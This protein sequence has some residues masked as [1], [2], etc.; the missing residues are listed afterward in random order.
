MGRIATLLLLCSMC[1]LGAAALSDKRF[2]VELKIP[3]AR[4]PYVA[5][6]KDTWGSY[7]HHR[8]VSPG[9]KAKFEQVPAGDFHLRVQFHSGRLLT[10]SFRVDRDHAADDRDLKLELRARDAET[11]RDSL[12]ARH[13]VTAQELKV[14]DDVQQRFRK[15]WKAMEIGSWFEARKL[16]EECVEKAPG[17]FDAWN[18]LGVVARRVDDLEAAEGHFRMALHLRPEAYEPHA[19]L[20]EVLS[21]LEKRDEALA[22]A[23]R[24]H[25]IRPNDAGANAMLGI[26]YFLAKQ[27]AECIPYLE[28]AMQAD[29]RSYYYPQI[30]LAVAYEKL[31]RPDAAARSLEHWLKHHATNP[32]RPVV[33]AKHRELRAA[34]AYTE[35]QAAQ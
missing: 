27:W 13:V 33:E 2:R 32:D 3:D 30:S 19:N 17:Y 1:A 6:L 22:M 18:N 10:R 23:K 25:R 12:G 16:L 8:Q 31:G 26:Q 11:T 20:S 29:P 9:G 5:V 14:S 35:T 34:S 4:E 15:A 28:A 7:L 21:A 24:A